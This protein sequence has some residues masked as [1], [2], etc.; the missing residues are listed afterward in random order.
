MNDMP[1]VLVN[2]KAFSISF[3][4]GVL[5]VNL[6]DL[7]YVIIFSLPTQLRKTNN[8]LLNYMKM[9]ELVSY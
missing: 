8:T 2:L 1:S 4:G 5:L 9:N 7:Y 3:L 6:F